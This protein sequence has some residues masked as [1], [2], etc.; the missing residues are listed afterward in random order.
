MDRVSRNY[1]LDL[2]RILAC[3]MVI[4]IHVSAINFYDINTNS[5]D[6]ITHNFFDSTLERLFLYL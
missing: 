1:N 3:F 2:L 5:I 6:F 4:L